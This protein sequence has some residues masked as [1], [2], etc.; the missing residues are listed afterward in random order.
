MAPDFAAGA[1]RRASFGWLPLHTFRDWPLVGAD[2]DGLLVAMRLGDCRYVDAEQR[3]PCT[4]DVRAEPVTKRCLSKIF[5]PAPEPVR[6]RLEAAAR[7][8]E[9]I[10]ARSAPRPANVTPGGGRKMQAHACLR[11]RPRHRGVRCAGHR[12]NASVAMRPA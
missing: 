7:R 11:W 2:D 3:M 5:N 1:A 4:P 9:A 6:P 10:A 8:A 12:P